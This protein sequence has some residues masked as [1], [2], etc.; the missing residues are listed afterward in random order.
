VARIK[1]GLQK[2]LYLG[3][4]DARR[5][6]GFAGDYVEAMWLMLQQQKPDDFVIA[7]GDTRTVREF[8]E[9]AFSEAG[10]TICWDGLGVD[11]KG[12]DGESGRT[13]IEIDKQYFR[14][15]EV[16][17]LQGDATKAKEKLGWSPKVGFEEL[18]KMM[19]VA[20]LEEA[21]H[22]AMCLREGY[23]Y[24]GVRQQ[25]LYSRS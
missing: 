15:T 22:E 11:E 21:E 16:D 14:P 23:C 3:N 9:R 25:N 8:C 17:I 24:N 7:T 20:D 5:D 4:L 19:V 6:W 1:L 10:Y 13:L 18:V 12:I 2:K